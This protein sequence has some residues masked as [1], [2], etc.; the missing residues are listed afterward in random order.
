M[1]SP[2]LLKLT[3][4][5]VA[6]LVKVQQVEEA[7]ELLEVT[8]RLL[9]TLMVDPLINLLAGSVEGIPTTTGLRVCV[10]A[11]DQTD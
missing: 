11:S 3:R 2:T 6:E 9:S 8:L 10:T 7:A 4:C 1:E 5:A